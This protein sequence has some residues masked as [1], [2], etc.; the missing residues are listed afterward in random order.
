MFISDACSF[1][2]LCSLPENIIVAFV[3]LLHSASVAT[4]VQISQTNAFHPDHQ[5][6]KKEG[7]IT[8]VAVTYPC[9]FL[10]A[11]P[12]PLTLSLA[13]L[14]LGGPGGAPEWSH[15]CR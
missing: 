2:P 8:R 6:L 10:G 11:G 15:G 1:S 3:F 12:V 9:S 5:H 4:S 13:S 7:G 14:V